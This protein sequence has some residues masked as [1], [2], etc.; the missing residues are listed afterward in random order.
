VRDF[1]LLFSAEIPKLCKKTASFLPLQHSPVGNLP[2]INNIQREW[3]WHPDCSTPY[4]SKGAVAMSKWDGGILLK[5]LFTLFLFVISVSAIPAAAG[6]VNVT[7]KGASG[8]AQGGVIVAPYY[9]SINGGP[10][11]PVVCDDYTHGVYTG[12]SWTATIN[13]FSTLASTRFGLGAFQQYAEAAWLVTQILAQPSQDGNLNFAIWALFAPTQ[14]KANTKGWTAGA[15]NWYKAAFAWFGS[16]CSKV[17]D[18]CSEINLANYAII[19]PTSSGLKSPQEYIVITPEPAT[20]ALF[21]AGLLLLALL[22]R[23]LLQIHTVTN[24]A[25]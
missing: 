24:A 12:E 25:H 8:V 13:T 3:S 1:T 7:L 14:T 11:I 15:Q 19:T 10:K 2:L 4:R 17:T 6:P 5:R 18:T 23:K 9:L 16:H 21:G 22:S 20:I